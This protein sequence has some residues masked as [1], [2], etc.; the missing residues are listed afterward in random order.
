MP[1]SGSSQYFAA[2]FMSWQ[3]DLCIV[4]SE[5]LHNCACFLSHHVRLEVACPLKTLWTIWNRKLKTLEFEFL[6]KK[7]D[8]LNKEIELV[9]GLRQVGIMRRQDI[10]IQRPHSLFCWLREIQAEVYPQASRESCR[11]W[12]ETVRSKTREK[13]LSM[14]NFEALIIFNEVEIFLASSF[15]YLSVLTKAAAW[16]GAAFPS[17]WQ[18]KWNFDNLWKL[19]TLH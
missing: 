18:R 5:R 10:G 17:W 1:A 7:K 14:G 9:E 13:E 4:Y 16:R 6:T 2:S 12:I 3:A 11:R 8:Y 19:R 15:N